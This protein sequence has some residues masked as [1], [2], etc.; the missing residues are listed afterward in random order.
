MKAI[1]KLLLGA[2]SVL[3]ASACMLGVAGCGGD[4]PE[5]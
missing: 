1:K 2:F 4:E 3:T 5:S